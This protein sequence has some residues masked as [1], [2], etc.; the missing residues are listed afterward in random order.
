[1]RSAIMGSDVFE[2]LDATEEEREA[3]QAGG[4]QEEGCH[5]VIR[6]G[7]ED[8]AV[9]TIGFPALSRRLRSGCRNADQ[10]WKA[11]LAGLWRN[12]AR[13][14]ANAYPAEME[15][16]GAGME[17]GAAVRCGPM[18]NERAGGMCVIPARSGLV[19]R[20]P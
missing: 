4:E 8:A 20:E 9:V 1:M 7:V 5:G 18:F 17:G 2:P 10:R 14:S 13:R 16:W 11:L 12:R 19:A 15:G 3:E 6:T